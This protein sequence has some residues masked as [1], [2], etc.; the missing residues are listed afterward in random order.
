MTTVLRP[1]SYF[2]NFENKIPGYT[3]SKKSFPG[4]VGRN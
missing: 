4:I 1:V 2:E 3:I